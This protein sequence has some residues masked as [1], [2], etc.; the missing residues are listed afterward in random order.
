MYIDRQKM[1]YEKSLFYG[2]FVK[3]VDLGTK[4]QRGCGVTV[5][6]YVLYI[7]NRIAAFFDSISAGKTII[8]PRLAIS[9]EFN[10]YSPGMI[11]INESVKSLIDERISVVDLTHGT[12]QYK[13][14]MGGIVNHCVE[15][16]ME[17]K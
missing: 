10:R 12:E 11:L 16:E 4:I 13:L 5:C 2:L 1:R 6:A 17:L 14:S 15:K 8:I 3:Y 7:N 9:D